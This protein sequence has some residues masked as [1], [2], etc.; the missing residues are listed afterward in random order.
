VQPLQRYVANNQWIRQYQP[1]ATEAI[2]NLEQGTIP[3][4]SRVKRCSVFETEGLVVLQAECTAKEPEEGGNWRSKLM[5]KRVLPPT[6]LFLIVI[7]LILGIFFRFV[8][9]DRKVY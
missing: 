3:A 9:L 2:V 8:N 4:L 1:A 6:W 7:I 5:Q